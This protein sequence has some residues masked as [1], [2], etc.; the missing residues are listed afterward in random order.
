VSD[1]PFFTQ[2]KEQRRRPATLHIETI[3][4]MS[5]RYVRW[6]VKAEGPL[7]VEIRSTKGGVARK[8]LE[9]E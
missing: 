1:D 7:A 8:T 3:P 2:P 9:V 5:A 6:L 4:G